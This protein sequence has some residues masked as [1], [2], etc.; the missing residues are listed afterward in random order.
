MKVKESQIVDT[1]FDLILIVLL[2]E[3]SDRQGKRMD[4]LKTIY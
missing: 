4:E 1:Q 2:N 3:L